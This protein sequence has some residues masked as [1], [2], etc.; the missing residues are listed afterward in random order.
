MNIN[1]PINIVFIWF[2]KV[3]FCK[4]LSLLVKS[5]HSINSKEN[6]VA[7]EKNDKIKEKKAESVIIDIMP[8]IK[9]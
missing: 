4:S 1:I 3:N 7:K 5:A 9:A 8:N 6:V 2:L